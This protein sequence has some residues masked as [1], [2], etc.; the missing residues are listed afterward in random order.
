MYLIKSNCKI[1]RTNLTNMARSF[2][3]TVLLF[4]PAMKGRGPKMTSGGTS[5]HLLNT[6]QERRWGCNG[7]ASKRAGQRE[8]E[9]ERERERGA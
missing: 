8:R 6:E 2:L 4:A 3:Q 9:R 7:G 5:K 1:S